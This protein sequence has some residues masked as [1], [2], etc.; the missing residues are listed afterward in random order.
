MFKGHVSKFSEEYNLLGLF[1][2]TLLALTASK[3]FQSVNV[4]V[5]D[6]GG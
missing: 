4:V 1:C 3:F 5:R 2:A 6:G